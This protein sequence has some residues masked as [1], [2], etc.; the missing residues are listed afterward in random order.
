[1]LFRIASLRTESLLTIAASLE[2]D[3]GPV[4]PTWANFFKSAS[5]L[6]Y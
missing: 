1:M 2:D 6:H 3:N 4:R 5:S